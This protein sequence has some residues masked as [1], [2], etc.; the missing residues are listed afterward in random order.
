[1]NDPWTWLTIATGLLV[2]IG[3]PILA[4]VGMVW[5]MRRLDARWQ[6]QA[7]RAVAPPPAEPPCWDVH[8]C[9]SEKRAVCAAY[10]HPENP[11]WQQ[12]RD[13][14]GN[15]RP[16]CLACELFAAVPVPQPARQEQHV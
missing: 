12:F 14:D 7:P 16:G 11:C 6:A 9:A 2:R 5:V 15:L 1:M 10:L 13:H 4:L 8:G 3:L